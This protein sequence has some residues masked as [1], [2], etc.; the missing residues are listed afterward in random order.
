MAG[1]E[2]FVDDPGALDVPVSEIFT[3]NMFDD[4]KHAMLAEGWTGIAET[5]AQWNNNYK[6]RTIITGFMKDKDIGAKRLASMPDRITNTI[7]TV[8]GSTDRCGNKRSNFA[9]SLVRLYTLCFATTMGTSI[10]ELSTT[11]EKDRWTT[12]E[13]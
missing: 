6:N 4:L 12:P 13:T 8:D 3:Q 11:R 5:E 7:N 2:A 10:P 1:I 9:A